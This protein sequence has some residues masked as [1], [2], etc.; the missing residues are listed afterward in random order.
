MANFAI[1]NIKRFD[2][3]KLLILLFLFVTLI[4]SYTFGIDIRKEATVRHKGIRQPSITRVSADYD[5]G[6]LA[7]DLLHYTGK[8]QVYVYNADGFVVGNTVSVISG[9]GSVIMDLD[10][11]EGN[12][13][14]CIVL[15]NTTYSGEFT[16]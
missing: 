12:Y 11:P 4:P 10:L 15:D 8:V 16:L 13:T 5:D 2:M 9:S 1:E 14:I 3:K 7:I 6:K